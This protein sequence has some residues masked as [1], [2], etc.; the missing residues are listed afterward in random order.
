SDREKEILSV[1]DLEREIFSVSR[2]WRDFWRA[3]CLCSG[4]IERRGPQKQKEKIEILAVGF[5]LG[6]GFGIAG[7]RNI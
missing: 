3:F 5:T 1:D 4:D 6:R 7:R 2:I